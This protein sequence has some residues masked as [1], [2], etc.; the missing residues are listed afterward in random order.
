MEFASVNDSTGPTENVEI[1][2]DDDMDLQTLEEQAE[3]IQLF[4]NML[5]QN[6]V[7]ILGKVAETGDYPGEWIEELMNALSKGR[8]NNPHS[9]SVRRKIRNGLERC[10][11]EQERRKHGQTKESFT[12]S[13][14][15]FPDAPKLQFETHYYDREGKAKEPLLVSIDNGRLEDV[16][17]LFNSLYIDFVLLP[18]NKKRDAASFT[19]LSNQVNKKR[20]I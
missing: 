2:T 16:A 1:G 17:F 13:N 20:K 11:Y 8:E 4:K 5:L 12:M 7:Y 3:Q 14:T 18:K 19:R 6:Q 15:L 10:F 9:E